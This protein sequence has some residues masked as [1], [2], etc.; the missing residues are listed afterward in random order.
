MVDEFP[1]GPP[2]LAFVCRFCT[3]MGE[4][5]KQ[6]AQYCRLQCGGPK[7]GQTFP[8]YNGPL[9]DGWLEGH[10]YLCGADAALT[11]KVQEQGIVGNTGRTLGVCRPHADLP[12][13]RS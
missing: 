5:I 9:T 8:L 6:G 12:R 13:P 2:D 3:K 10:C 1:V 4:Q 7:K 11:L